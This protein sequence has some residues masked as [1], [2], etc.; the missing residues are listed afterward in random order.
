M[1]GREHVWALL[2]LHEVGAGW[3]EGRSGLD[4]SFGCSLFCSAVSSLLV[5]LVLRHAWIFVDDIP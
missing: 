4:L 3:M 1:S 5:L 2:F